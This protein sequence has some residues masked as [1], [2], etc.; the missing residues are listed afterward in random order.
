MVQIVLYIAEVAVC[1]MVHMGH[2]N[3]GSQGICKAYFQAFARY[4]LFH[5]IL[6]TFFANIIS[7]PGHRN[8]RKSVLEI[9]KMYYFKI[10]I[11][12]LL[13]NKLIK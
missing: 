2:G 13:N 12:K 3:P 9:T 6:S 1:Y 11:I 8:K 5:K 4:T 10:Q 7:L